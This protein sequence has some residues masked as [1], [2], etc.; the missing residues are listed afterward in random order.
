MIVLA[1]CGSQGR[2]GVKIA[3]PKLGMTI[4]LPV[5]WQAEAKMQTNFFDPA[6]PDD[7]LGWVREYPLEGI[8]FSESVDRLIASGG[9]RVISRKARTISGKDAIEV[10]TQANYTMI[11]VCILDGKRVIDVSFQTRTQDFA[12][13][14][15][16][17]RRAL[18]SIKF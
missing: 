13:H 6:K 11:E 7:N 1:G 8:S 12:R 16:E 17:L 9:A 14:E 2:K 3:L 4:V 5:G 10:L 18:E 15:R